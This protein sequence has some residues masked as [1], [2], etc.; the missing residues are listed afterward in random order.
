EDLLDV[1]NAEHL[2]GFDAARAVAGQQQVFLD[3]FAL[4]RLAGL[5]RKQ[6]QDAIGVAH[7]GDLGVDHHH[8]LVGVVHGQEG[9]LFDAGG[10]VG[11]DVVEAVLLQL[12]EDALDALLGQ[13][14]LVPGL[15]GGKDVQVLEALVL[16]QGLL[17]AR[18]AIDDV[19]EVVNH[20]ALAPHD[21]VKVAQADVE[22][23]DGDLVA[24][25][26]KTAGDRGAA[27][28]LA[29]ATLARG[30]YDDFGQVRFLRNG[31]CARQRGRGIR[32]T[33]VEWGLSFAAASP[34]DCDRMPVFGLTVCPAAQCGAGRPAARPAPACRAA[35]PA[36]LPS[37]CNAR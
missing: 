24:A 2:A 32:R 26:G 15:G 34:R 6:P 14:I 36:G 19:D 4:F 33:R 5:A 30:D 25:T 8:R 35:P 11:D 13:R 17:E 21:Q 7:R 27:G 10:G 28:G 1:A 29:H 37:P 16:D 22:V 9:A 12:L 3:P 23:D 31:L 18:L 20:A